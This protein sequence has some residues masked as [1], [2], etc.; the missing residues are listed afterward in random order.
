MN[1]IG[2]TVR[3]SL[4]DL[5]FVVSDITGVVVFMSKIQ[6]FDYWIKSLTV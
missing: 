5:L 4:K 1:C 3:K 2:Y 6:C